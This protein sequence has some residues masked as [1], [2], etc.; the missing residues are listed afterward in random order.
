MS[1]KFREPRSRMAELLARDGM[2][3]GARKSAFL[4]MHG[5]TIIHWYAA[6][7]N[8]ALGLQ[9]VSKYPPRGITVPRRTAPSS[10]RVL[11]R[12]SRED[13]LFSGIWIRETLRWLVRSDILMSKKWKGARGLKRKCSA[14]GLRSEE[15]VKR[16]RLL[17]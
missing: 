8:R 14:E 9:L 6:C 5:I 1:K 10:S 11:W 15:V 4:L 7:K 12:R 13:A 16:R 17:P 2:T 3:T